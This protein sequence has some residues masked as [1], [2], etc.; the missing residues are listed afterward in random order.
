MIVGPIPA[1][2]DDFCD[3]HG[4]PDTPVSRIVTVKDCSGQATGAGGTLRL[5]YLP[6]AIFKGRYM[7]LIRLTLK[8]TDTGLN[9]AVLS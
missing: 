8:S 2:M 6:T 5:S 4:T 9:K 3:L 7:A 1:Q